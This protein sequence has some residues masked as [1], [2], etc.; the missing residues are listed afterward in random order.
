[1]IAIGYFSMRRQ[2]SI[3][4]RRFHAALVIVLALLWLMEVVAYL[5]DR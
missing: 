1:V 5:I 2:R 3:R 4:Q